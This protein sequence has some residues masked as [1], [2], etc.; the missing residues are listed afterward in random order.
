[1]R[2]KGPRRFYAAKKFLAQAGFKGGRCS[3]GVVDVVS[4][5]WKRVRRMI[6]GEQK[7]FRSVSRRP[8]DTKCF[9]CF[10]IFSTLCGCILDQS[11]KLALEKGAS[12]PVQPPK[13]LPSSFS[14][15]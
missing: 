3:K 13:L 1:M 2:K 11:P 12:F 15:L 8:K 7:D 4:I 9:A 10:E 14:P 5:L 6:S